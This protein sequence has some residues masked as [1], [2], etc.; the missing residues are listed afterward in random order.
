MSLQIFPVTGIGEVTPGADLAELIV[1]AA[2][3]LADGDVLVVT[4]KIISKA[5]GRLVPLPAPGPARE[6]ARIDV[7]AG[8]T[9]RT[10]AA[11]GSTRIV[12]THHGFVMASA[13]VDA[14]NVDSD[15]VVLL[16]KDPDG[17]AR[18]LRATL[19]AR[20]HRRVAVVVS[21]TMGRPWRNGLTDVALGAAGIPPLRDHRGETD[22]YGNPLTLTQQAQVDQLAAAADLVKGKIDGVPVAVVRGLPLAPPDGP[23]RDGVTLTADPPGV[24]ETLVRNP[25]DDLFSLG[26]AEARAAGLRA[27]ATLPDTPPLALHALPAAAL[28]EVRRAVALVTGSAAASADWVVTDGPP[29]VVRGT[30]AGAPLRLGSD[31]HRLRAALAAAGLATAVEYHEPATALVTVGADE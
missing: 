22:R 20:H 26:T 2:P 28:A 4:S 14:S 12:A 27:A 10:V 3:W 19:A 5:E 17:A 30:S 1:T 25:A 31:V 9:A 18:M 29:C 6:T 21:D 15:H 23:A 11:R 16:P 24:V 7:I 13:G 8:E